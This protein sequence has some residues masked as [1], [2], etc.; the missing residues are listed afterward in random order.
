MQSL[1]KATILMLMLAISFGCQ[2]SIPV[3]LGYTP[4]AEVRDWAANVLAARPS[5]DQSVVVLL[6]DSA[7][8]GVG[9]SHVRLQ[10]P[11][12]RT[13]ASYFLTSCR[14]S[15]TEGPIPDGLYDRTI[16]L[17]FVRESTPIFC[18]IRL[19]DLVDQHGPEVAKHRQEI[20]KLLL[21][22]YRE[23]EARKAAE[24]KRYPWMKG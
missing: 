6:Q 4:N 2:K 11:R 24:R 19:K 14:R 22:A 3:P 8:L 5:S 9:D 17:Q 10:G 16:T 20:R 21:E 7:D 1:V 23:Q 15:G 18:S 13:L 12:L